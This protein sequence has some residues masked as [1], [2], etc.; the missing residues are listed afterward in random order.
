MTSGL[1]NACKKKNLLY[2]MFL[3]S[4][5]KQSEDKYKTYKNKLT[6]ILRKCEKNYN[7]KLLELNK[8]NLKETWKLLNSIINKKKKTMQVGH[9]FENKGESITGDEHIAN[10]FN[11]YF[12]N[13]GPSLA[14]NIPATDTQFSQYLSA[15]TNVKNSL[16]L[17]PVTEVEILQLV[18]KLKPK[19]SKGHDELDMCLIKKL[20]PY[21]VVP[22]KHIFNLSLLNG[23]FPDSMKIARVIPLFKS[24][25]TKEFSNYRP[26]SLLPQFSKILEKIYHSRLMAFIDSNQVLYKSQYGFRKQM[27]TSL[28][29]IELVEEI[30]NS[31]DNHEATVGVFIDLKKAFDTVDHS[32]LIEKLYHYGIRGTANKWICSYLMNRYQYVTINGTNSDYMNVLCGV[33]QGSIL[34]PILFILYIN[35][36]CNVSTLLKPILFAD[37]TNLFYS[38]KDIDE[39]CSVVSIELDKLCVWFQV[40]KLSLNTSKTNFMI[41]TN[42]SCDDTYSVCM[43]GLNLSRVFVTKFLGVHMDSKLDW[44][45]HI[46]IVRNKV[47]K[48]VSVMNRVKHVLP[49]S[50]LYSLYCTLVMPYLTYC[51]EVWG[52]NY[53]TRIQSLFILQKRAIRIC[54][55]TNYKC[56]TKPLFYQLRSLNV[57]DII[58]LNSLVFMYKAFHN[59]LPTN[60]LSY[61]KKVNDSHNHNIR[62]NTLSFK[63]RFR[64][65]SK[66]ALSI[67]IKGCKMWNALSPD[68]KLSRNANAFKKM[69][70]SSLLEDYKF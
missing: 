69:L 25:N 49:N 60:L 17:N 65:T 8:G 24:G 57:F 39:L 55:N 29:I 23:V 43:N 54:L 10:G 68:I 28:A 6:T 64:R 34:G 4:R 59:L 51:C 33:P 13:V 22:L 40:N 1:K 48:N 18:A 12:V 42:R 2:K 56:H 32:I 30:T 61:F 26:I 53:K 21:I 14:D 3:K 70:K 5:S 15:S 27:S 7:T 36:M 45:Y 16:F 46:G 31:L 52:N 58:D 50:A 38:G 62:N 20:I 44:N 19:K 66:K 11:D 35:D 67:C 47:A 9:E 37:D 41:F 63:V